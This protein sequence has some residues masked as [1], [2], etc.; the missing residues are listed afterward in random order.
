MSLKPAL[1]WVTSQ[2]WAHLRSNIKTGEP[3]ATWDGNP[4]LCVSV[5]L[6]VRAG[7]RWRI[8]KPDDP[9]T[10]FLYIAYLLVDPSIQRSHGS[11]G[12]ERHQD[13]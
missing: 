5:G 2:A 6:K 1:I 10:H 3:R 11:K 12:D 7:G 4:H 13:D 9:G 8:S